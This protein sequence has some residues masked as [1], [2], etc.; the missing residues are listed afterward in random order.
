MRKAPVISVHWN[1]RETVAMLSQ[2]I[3]HTGQIQ[4]R[5]PPEHNHAL[6]QRLHPEA[7][8]STIENVNRSGDADL[9][10]TV[11]GIDGLEDLALIVDM[12]H[13]E[14]ASVQIV[15]PPEVIIRIPGKLPP[16]A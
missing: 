13:A 4:L 8:G 11:S 14:E 10:K 1:G 9:L 3:A 2:A 7:R 5:L 12:L 16:A 15:S 6:F